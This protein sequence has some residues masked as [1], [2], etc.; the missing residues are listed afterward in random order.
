VSD[1]AEHESSSDD[2][3][4]DGPANAEKPPA[5]SKKGRPRQAKRLEENIAKKA[6]PQSYAAYIQGFGGYKAV[7]LIASLILLTEVARVARD[8][9]MKSQIQKS[10]SSIIVTALSSHDNSAFFITIYACLGIVQGLLSGMANILSVVCCTWASRFIHFTCIR[11]VLGAKLSVFD[12]TPVGRILSRFSRDLEIIDNNFP[13]KLTFMVTC[14]STM[15]AAFII[16][17][18]TAPAISITFI[19]PMAASYYV[20]REFS[21]VWRQLQQLQGQAFGPIVS[22]FGESLSGLPTIRAFGAGTLFHFSSAQI[23]LM[24]VRRWLG[25]RSELVANAYVFLLMVLCIYL[26]MPPEIVGLLITYMVNAADCIDW[27][28]KTMSEV[29]NCFVSVER[30][31]K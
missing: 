15:L 11:C 10:P 5:A 14:I 19:L 24:G 6:S 20:Q 17:L 9:F 29:D 26:E 28:M 25:L 22:H 3:A 21:R 13:D 2:E 27:C 18:W 7:W 8:L 1:A 30:L 16:I 12:V 23:W 31:N 4:D